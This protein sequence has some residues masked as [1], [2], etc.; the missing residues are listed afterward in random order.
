MHTRLTLKPGQK[1]TKKLVAQ[2]GD[3]LVCIRY[4][5]DPQTKKRYKTVELIV[6]EVAW[7]PT[8]SPESIV[9]IRVAR[10]EAAIIQQVKGAGGK[11]NAQQRVWE[12]RYDQVVR[13]GLEGRIVNKEGI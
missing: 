1:G 13:L 8:V 10:E 7:T 6:E 9:Q 11:W 4:R 3:K 5:Y 2:Y 12:I